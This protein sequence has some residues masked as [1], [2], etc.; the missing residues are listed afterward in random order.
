MRRAP[1]ELDSI[2]AK[3][4]L[5]KGEVAAAFKVVAPHAADL[6]KLPAISAQE[7]VRAILDRA[8]FPVSDRTI[9]KILDEIRKL[10]EEM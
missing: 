8:D 3:T 2:S 4:G 1:G 6:L 7:K 10:Y 5:G 9:A